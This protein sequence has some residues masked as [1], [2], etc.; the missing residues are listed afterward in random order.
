MSW[1]PLTPTP[2]STTT[3]TSQAST[4][5]LHTS[6]T[7]WSRKPPKSTPTSTPPSS[8][9]GRMPPHHPDQHPRRKHRPRKPATLHAPARAT[10]ADDLHEAIEHAIRY[11]PEA[12][13][14]LFGVSFAADLFGFFYEAAITYPATEQENTEQESA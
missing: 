3:T 1:N 6:G 13:L 12:Y 5:G 4:A 11:A 14:E 2:N 7:C 9:C 10:F 8:R